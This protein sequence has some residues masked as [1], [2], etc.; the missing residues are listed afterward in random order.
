MHKKATLNIGRNIRGTKR[1]V[2]KSNPNTH[3]MHKKKF[4]RAHK[5]V[6]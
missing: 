1:N 6:R 4:K 3:R 2:G 5:E